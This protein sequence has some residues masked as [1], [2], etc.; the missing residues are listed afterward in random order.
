MVERKSGHIVNMSSDAGRR[1]F[2]G[3]AVYSGSKFFVEGLSQG[4][5][6]ELAPIGVRVTCIQ[7]GDVKTELIQHT[8]DLEVRSKFTETSVM[9]QLVAVFQAKEAYDGS[10]SS[11]ILNPDDVARAVA[12]AVTQPPYVAI[13]EILIEPREAPI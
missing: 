11:H 8:T 3:L 1:G 12:Y 5:R 2:A 13:N 4:M 10:G 6:H 9:S 7:P